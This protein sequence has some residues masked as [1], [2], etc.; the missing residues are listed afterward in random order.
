M[1]SVT[2]RAFGHE[3]VVGD[4]RTTLE[5][6]SEKFLTKRGTC[7]IGIGSNLTLDRI[8]N[9][10]KSLARQRDTEIQLRISAGGI[11]EIITGHGSAG[12]TYESTVSMVARTS[13]FECPR[14]LMIGADKAASD[15]DRTLIEILRDPEVEMDCELVFINQ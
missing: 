4:H 2:F 12:L 8:D 14:T 1:H 13:G 15:I 10:I 11:T 7:I 5:I 9:V 3:N 6:T